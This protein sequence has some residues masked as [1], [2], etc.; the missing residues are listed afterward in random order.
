LYEQYNSDATAAQS[1]T[2]ELGTELRS[3]E[4]EIDRL[5]SA[6]RQHGPAASLINERIWSYLGHKELEIQ[7]HEDG[8]QLSRNGRVVAGT[9]C[10]GEK[11]AIALCYFLTTLKAEGR[12]LKDLIVV[13]D[14]PIS[15]L[16]TRALNYAFNMIK[17]TLKDVAQ[18]IVLTH[19]LNFMN[20]TKKWLRERTEK[21]V[22]ERGE[23]PRRITSALFF[24][25]VFQPLHVIGRSSSIEEMPKHIREYE[26]EYQYL[27]HMIVKFASSQ[28]DDTGYFYIVPNA[29]RKALEIFL[30]FKF[31]GS[32]GLSG[33]ME[34]LAKYPHGLDPVRIRALDR[35][36]Q[37]ESHGD[38]LDDLVTFS[39]MTIEEVKKAAS[40]FLEVIAA[41]DSGHYQNM[42]SL[43]RD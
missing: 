40:I 37:V 29:L 33:K 30:A 10:E 4:L 34:S 32:D 38:N 35:L 15:S 14:D 36:V 26:S 6:V 17:A 22:L 1:M 2:Q 43:C 7:T 8:Y 41:V 24:L 28:Y 31:P 21:R 20:E 16:D 25:N 9:L 19:N 23:N 27:F 13:L 18:L 42:R 11:T 5:K 3:L 39:S 12:N